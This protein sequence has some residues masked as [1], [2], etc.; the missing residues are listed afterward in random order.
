MTDELRDCDRDRGNSSSSKAS[1]YGIPSS[2]LSLA[3]SKLAKARPDFLSLSLIIILSFFGSFLLRPPPDNDE[4]ALDAQ[5][6]T[7]TR[8]L[9]LTPSDP[10][11]SWL[12]FLLCAVPADLVDP[13]ELGRGVAAGDSRR[14]TLKPWSP[15]PSSSD[16]GVVAL[17]V[18]A[19]VVVLDVDEI[20]GVERPNACG[21]ALRRGVSVW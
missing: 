10:T 1:S 8:L 15:S 5:P 4:T 18:V 14:L 12:Y 9:P 13:R 21:A 17:E 19:L 20:E 16:T 6:A 11:L 7:P 3:F 2:S